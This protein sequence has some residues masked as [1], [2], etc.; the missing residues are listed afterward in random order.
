[1]CA[2]R[3]LATS[4]LVGMQPSL[5]QVP[6]RCSRS[7]STVFMPTCARRT[8]R[9][10]PAWPLPMTMASWVLVM[11]VLPCG[12]TIGQCARRSGVLD[13]ALD[14]VMGLCPRVRLDHAQRVGVAGLA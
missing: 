6:P 13:D 1:M 11:V 14:G 7:I 5:T 12:W 8:A 9:K 2:A 3:A 4:V 10:G